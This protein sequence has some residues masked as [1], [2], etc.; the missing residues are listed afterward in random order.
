ILIILFF[1]GCTHMIVNNDNIKQHINQD[2]DNS[3]KKEIDKISKNLINTENNIGLVVAVLHN[4]KTDI[5]TYGYANKNKK[6]PMNANTIFAL[7][8][9]SK[10]LI[11][12]L[13]LI[14]E[15]K[16]IIKLDEK[17]S[18]ILPK[19]IKYKDIDVKNITLR[20]LM[21]HSSNLPREPYDFKTFSSMIGYFFSGENIYSHIDTKYMY[22]YLEDLE[23]KKLDLKKARYSNIG[24]GLLAYLLTQKTNKS[25]EELMT[26]YIYEPL[27]LKNTTF[28]LPKDNE[29]LAV[30]H[31][32]DLP[33]FIKA[34]T[35]LENWQ[36]SDMMIGTGG[37]YSSANDLIKIAKAHL[38]L[39]STYLDDILK[40]SHK[41]YTHDE[42]LAYTLGWQVKV[43][44]NTQIHY[45][46]GVIAGFSTYIGMNVKTKD[47]V[48]VLKNNFNWK[49]YI[50][51]N[52]LLKLDQSSFIKDLDSPK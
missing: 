18:D 24:S 41:I 43:F 26:K 10:M 50:G 37:A 33:L 30:G 45:K 13:A 3:I 19:S 5:Y 1:N 21:L 38:L 9:N 39:S 44:K 52:T 8:S 4:K 15:N 42:E 11:S 48:I 40:K 22:K 32:G 25:L 12:S 14:L 6:I 17:I 16:K 23:I 27:N 36:F 20:N 35:P 47:A 31:V 7:G 2:H 46:Y 28:I 49:D 29:Q 51:H 34:N